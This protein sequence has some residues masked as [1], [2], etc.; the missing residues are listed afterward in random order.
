MKIAVVTPAHNVARYIGDT[1]ASLIAQSHPDW[2]MV[3]VDD[4]STDATAEVVAGFPDPRIRLIR[5][6]NQG[7]SAARNRGIEEAD[8]DSE[9]VLFLDAD[10]FLAPDALARLTTTLAAAP[11]AVAAYGAYAFVAEDAHPGSR[12]LEVKSGPFPAGDIF[13]ALVERNLF[14]NGGHLLIARAALDGMTGF[15]ADLQFGEDWEFWIRLS[16]HG[17]FAVVQGASP[18]LFV[19]RRPS[20][21]YLRMAT[22]PEAF[23]PCL[24]AIF[25]SPR[26][27]AHLGT[28]RRYALRQRAEAE[29]SWIVG[30]ELIRHGRDIEG[31]AWLRQAVAMKPSSKRLALLCLAYLLD[32][33]P[34]SRRGPF[35][36]YDAPIAPPAGAVPRRRRG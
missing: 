6:D 2:A 15:R 35:R 16:L 7:V 8:E 34:P 30:R 12:A 23:R 20:G 13:D 25:A 9:A 32:W 4:G 28:A 36:P 18:L 11:R 1:I 17:P 31:R 14:A 27:L 24:E 21:A 5:Q 10:D 22:Q 3:V 33:L 26:M 19:R 29:N